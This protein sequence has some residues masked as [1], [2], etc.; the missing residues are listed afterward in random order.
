MKNKI[1]EYILFIKYFL[2]EFNNKKFFSIIKILDTINMKFL[3][4]IKINNYKKHLFNF[5]YIIIQNFI[6]IFIFN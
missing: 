2:Y 1:I 5:F 3:R 4:I 6:N